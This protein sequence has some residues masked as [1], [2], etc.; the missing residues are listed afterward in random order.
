MALPVVIF[1][2][3]SKEWVSDLVAKAK[4]LKVTYGGEK[5]CD[6]G[7]LCYPEVK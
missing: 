7:P 5:D 2:G 1:V 6:V 3:K 4:T